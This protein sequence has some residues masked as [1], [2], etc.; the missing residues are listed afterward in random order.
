[1]V[2]NASGRDSI[3]HE[4]LVDLVL[5]FF[6]IPFSERT[7]VWPVWAAAVK[8]RPD[9]ANLRAGVATRERELLEE[10]S[11]VVE[12]RPPS[13]AET[14]GSARPA[15]SDPV[16][17]PSALLAVVPP[18]EATPLTT[19]PPS[20]VRQ[21]TGDTPVPKHGIDGARLSEWWRKLAGAYRRCHEIRDNDE[22]DHLHNHERRYG[23]KVEAKNVEGILALAHAIIA[24]DA[25]FLCDV[26]CRHVTGGMTPE[27][28]KLLLD[29]LQHD[30]A[31]SHRYWGE[32]SDAEW[33]EDEL[34]STI[35]ARDGF[36]E[37]LGSD[38]ASGYLR[39]K[40]DSPGPVKPFPEPLS[41]SDSAPRGCVRYVTAPTPVVVPAEHAL[42]PEPR[43]E[44][45]LPEHGMSGA[46]LTHW[47]RNVT[48]NVEWRTRLFFERHKSS[49]PESMDTRV[50][51]FPR[52]YE[53][54]AAMGIPGF[55]HRVIAPNVDT[56]CGAAC[57]HVMAGM[58]AE[59][60][61]GVLDR[62]DCDY[63]EATSHAFAHLESTLLM[64]EIYDLEDAR[65]AFARL[66]G[67][68]AVS[69][70]LG[71]APRP[72]T[73][74]SMVQSSPPAKTEPATEREM[75]PMD[76]DTA[77]TPA[78]KDMMLGDTTIV[79]KGEMLTH[80]EIGRRISKAFAKSFPGQPA[81]PRPQ[82]PERKPDS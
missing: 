11:A 12:A 65:N 20:S 67:S 54:M 66:L 8:S 57:P 51:R 47:W 78:P 10:Y 46:A 17:V 21:V 63:R 14:G 68:E 4:T 9:G 61:R 2:D 1:M 18:P 76:G 42:A 48:A 41:A 26:N 44:I 70:H 24:P 81:S 29:S 64:E 73:P 79:H 28:A 5:T 36:L 74:P 35:S 34:C 80:E 77:T 37:L 60:A 7:K 23:L 72:A 52:M 69:K 59:Q 15:P 22:G 58:T 31:A 75:S 32:H 27:Q 6:S 25:P 82:K 55:V 50:L 56:L 38:S 30:I 53:G 49:S 39:G 19:K 16:D 43:A 33:A 45:P 3:Y 13:T 71:L 40:M 62:L